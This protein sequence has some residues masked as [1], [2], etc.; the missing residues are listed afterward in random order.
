MVISFCK[1][2][3]QRENQNNQ[4]KRKYC[5]EM[6]ILNGIHIMN[7]VVLNSIFFRLR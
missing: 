1:Q 6:N 4:E 7:R 3:H 2:K 5:D